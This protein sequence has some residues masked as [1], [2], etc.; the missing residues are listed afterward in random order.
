MPGPP[1]D[2]D[3]L[4]RDRNTDEGWHVLPVTG[5][6][7]PTPDW[8]LTPA[9]N[10]EAWHWQRL[11]KTPQATRWEVLGQ[12]VQV[13]MYVR[14]LVAAEEPDATAALGNHIL[15]LEEGLGLSI[16]GMRRN[17]WQIGSQQSAPATQATGTEGVAPRRSTSSPKGR[18]SVVRDDGA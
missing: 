18:L 17:R 11:W 4:R 10:R 12:H 3:A 1:P 7:G 8:P 5:R 15:R 14:R 2:P 9:G 16:P 13:A 6:T